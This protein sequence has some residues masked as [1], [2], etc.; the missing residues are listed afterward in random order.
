MSKGGEI[1]KSPKN[2]TPVETGVQN[3]LKSLDSGV[4]RNDEKRTKRTFYEA[5]KGDRWKFGH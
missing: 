2:V 4:R 3:Q 1:V 5:I